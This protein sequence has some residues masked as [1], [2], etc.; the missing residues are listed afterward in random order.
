M[1]I[2]DTE[3]DRDNRIRA[4]YPGSVHDTDDVMLTATTT[5]YRR[6]GSMVS[7]SPYSMARTLRLLRWQPP[8]CWGL[9]SPRLLA[10]P[11]DGHTIGQS[12]D[13]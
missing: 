10:G 7:N 3:R 8:C 5:P 1:S 12:H 9:C 2:L 11:V 13:G 6:V 4:D